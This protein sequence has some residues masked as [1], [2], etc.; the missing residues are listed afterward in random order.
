MR[1]A[2]LENLDVDTLVK[3]RTSGID[4]EFIRRMKKPQK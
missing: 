3:L 2:G 1:D 4:G